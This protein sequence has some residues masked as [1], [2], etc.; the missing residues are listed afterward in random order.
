MARNANAPITLDAPTRGFGNRIIADA[1]YTFPT[2]AVAAATA[3]PLFILPKGAR[4]LG[5]FIKSDDADSNGAPT[6]T[7]SVGDVASNVRYLNASTVA[8]AGG[9]VSFTAVGGINFV[10]TADTL[11]SLTVTAAAATQTPGAVVYVAI[12]YVEA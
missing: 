3:I 10:L 7:L 8:Q 2:A 6:I 9:V 1:V 5:G 12:D 11:V 4:I